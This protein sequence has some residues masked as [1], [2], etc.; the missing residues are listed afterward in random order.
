MT[1]SSAEAGGTDVDGPGYYAF[2]I[3]GCVP[4]SLASAG[5]FSFQIFCALIH[6]GAQFIFTPFQLPKAQSIKTKDR[7]PTR[8]YAAKHKQRSFLEARC[9]IE[10]H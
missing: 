7:R 3:H 5:H 9:E 6:Q 2:L 8:Q 1:G 10:G 4:L